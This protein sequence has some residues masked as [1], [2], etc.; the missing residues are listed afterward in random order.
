MSGEAL[1]V[2]GY[3]LGLLAVGAGL[4]R[5]GRVNTDAWSSRLFAGYRAQVPDAPPAA[6]AADWPHSEAPRLYTVIAAVAAVAALVLCAGEIARH[7]RP[8]EAAALLAVAAAAVV[9]LARFVRRMR[10]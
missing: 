1:F 10:R 7:H 6:T 5:L 8:V 9:T 2:A 3:A 4:H